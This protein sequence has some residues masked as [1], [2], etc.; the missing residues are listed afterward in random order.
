MRV[1]GTATSAVAIEVRDLAVAYDGKAVFAGVS[2]DVRRGEVFVILGGSGCGKST[3]L[4]RMIGLKTPEAGSVRFS[5]ADIVTAAG[6]AR[7]ALLRS[8]GVMYQGG[9]LFGS[10]TVLENVRL[11][12]DEFT[13]LPLAARNLVALGKLSLVGLADALF[14]VLWY[15]LGW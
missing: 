3:L 5:G 7:T 15:V 4:K 6:A 13:S 1:T 14:S 2:F 9:A 10:M 11:P 12:L 8:F